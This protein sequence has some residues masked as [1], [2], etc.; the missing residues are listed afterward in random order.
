M[1]FPNE[2]EVNRIKNMYPKGTRVKLI[3]MEDPHGVPEGTYGNIFLVDDIGQLHVY[4]DNGSSLAL[5]PGVDRFEV[6]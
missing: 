4:W 1:R 6:V 3:S 2:R 5:I